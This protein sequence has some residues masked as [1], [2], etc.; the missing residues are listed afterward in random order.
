[1]PLPEGTVLEKTDICYL[2]EEITIRY[3]ALTEEKNITLSLSCPLNTYWIVTNPETLEVVIDS[4]VRNMLELSDNHS[5]VELS[6][7]P[8]DLFLII[9]LLN[10]SKNTGVEQLHIFFADTEDMYQKSLYKASELATHVLGGEI[11]YDCSA[12]VGT[13]F[14]LKIKEG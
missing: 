1:M 13:Y 4:M 6:I 2:L 8:G 11:S 3:S 9:E 7:I 12:D 10:R 5:L 14:R